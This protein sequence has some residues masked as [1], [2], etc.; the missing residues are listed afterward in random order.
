MLVRP[1]VRVLSEVA[2]D[3]RV[4]WAIDRELATEAAVDVLPDWDRP[5]DSVVDNRVETL[6]SEETVAETLVELETSPDRAAEIE[7]ARVDAAVEV[8]LAEF[9][10]LISVDVPVEATVRA[11]VWVDVPA[12]TL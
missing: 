9:S 8:T 7:T 11:L 2:L 10:V 3:S 12:D 1:E 4:D 5:V 6:V